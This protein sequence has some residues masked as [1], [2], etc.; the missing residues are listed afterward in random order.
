MLAPLSEPT[1]R[2]RVMTY[3]VHGFVGTDGAFDP[4]RV[5]RVI[6][7]VDPDLVALQEVE[8]GRDEDAQGATLGWL[9]QRL[10]MHGHFTLTRPG[11][12]GGRFGNAVLSRHAFELISEGSLPRRGG[13]HRAVQWLKV[14]AASGEFH[15]MNTH[16]GIWFW[17]R[18]A[19]VRALLGTEWLLRA[20][21]ALPVVVCGDFNAT[22]LSP[23]YRALARGLRDVR[24]G[25]G[26]KIGTWPS[27][28][29]LLCIDHMFVSS[30]FRVLSCGV[31]QTAESRVASDHLPLVAELD[32]G[33]P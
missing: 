29:P 7:Q 19:Q 28:R 33:S 22:S 20:G 6:E 17:E 9:G 15:L 31:T 32:W 12:T 16:L 27:A 14:R 5:A 8:L 21:D 2:A 10:G 11:L 18:H 24:R 1:H 25:A 13:E 4:E 23:V 30:E 3:N 26:R